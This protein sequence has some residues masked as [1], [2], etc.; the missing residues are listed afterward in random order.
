MANGMREWIEARLWRDG[1]RSRF[2]WA[3]IRVIRARRLLWRAYYQARRA[4]RKHVFREQPIGP[5]LELRAPRG[6]SQEDERFALSER[7]LIRW[8]KGDG[9]DDDVTRSAIAQATRLFGDAVDYC[10]AI[11]HID[12][13]R[14]LTIVEWAAQPV[15]IWSQAPEDNLALTQVLDL[16]G[17]PPRRFGYWWKWFPSRI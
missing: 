2:W 14:A 13:A 17:C 3:I 15:H 10:L 5:S 11:N 16:A 4:L 12:M 8:V 7:P 1:E 6:R 9:L